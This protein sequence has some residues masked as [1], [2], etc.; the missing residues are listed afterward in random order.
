MRRGLLPSR[1][2][3]IAQNREE[4]GLR[5]LGLRFLSRSRRA[6]AKAERAALL[7]ALAP[8]AQWTAHDTKLHLGPLAPGCRHCVAGGW[9]C[10]FVNGRCNAACSYC[11]TPQD[12]VDLPGTN[13]LSFRRPA[14]YAAYL[15]HFGF[16]GA[17]A[18]GGEPLLTPN[19][20]L[21]FLRAMRAALGD[22][23]H[24]WLY[25]NGILLTRDLAR[26]LRE[27]GLDEIR[28]DIGAT[29]YRLDRLKEVAGI[30]PTLTVEIPLVPDE[31]T[32]LA[33][34]LR[35]LAE[36][37][38]QHLNLHQLRL[39]P[40][41]YRHL[42]DRGFRFLHGERIT[43]LES[44]LGALRLM[45]QAADQAMPLAINY[46]SYVFK[47]RHQGAA[48]R[49][50]AARVLCQPWEAV[51]EAGYLRRV[52]LMG[53]P[54]A[55]AKAAARLR[56]RGTDPRW[57]WDAD[58]QPLALHPELLP[59]LPLRGLHLLVGY[60]EARQRQATSAAAPLDFGLTPVRFE[61]VTCRPLTPVR[62]AALRDLT[63]VSGCVP[64][65]IV[66][67]GLQEYF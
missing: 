25:T 4:Y 26:Q 3:L 21:A 9:S 27:V 47:S 1:L 36:E 11:P 5:Y 12:K 22:S 62:P 2:S 38:V 55:L 63:A 39:T 53:A 54:E 60:D 16:T 45:Q 20:T 24:L 17:S 61:R 35:P 40:H 31:E 10:L 44:E 32:R 49:Q 42:A 57:L 43:V 64:W 8:V 51:T 65:E 66:P 67:T 15:R 58:T 28:L 34:L 13:H 33:G 48:A 14:D 29:G 59:G 18:S 6:A 37:G 30:I 7:A 23:G 50:R 56:Q 19:R 46:C 41:N 52:A